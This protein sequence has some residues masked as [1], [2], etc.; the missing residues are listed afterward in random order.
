MRAPAR[1][2]LRS[3]TFAPAVTLILSTPSW[4]AHAQGAAEPK[5]PAQLG[6]ITVQT[7]ESEPSYTAETI[8]LGKT[9]QTLR[10]T[11]QSVSVITRQ[12]IEDQN[13]T[14]LDD[15]LAQSTGITVRGNP[16]NAGFYSRGFVIQQAQRDGVPVE[17]GTNT[18]L[19]SPDLAIYERVEILRGAAGL[20]NGA[21]QPGGTLNL[22]RKRALAETRFQTTATA[23]SWNNYR[24][25]ADATGELNGSGTLRGRLV[26]VYHSQESFRD[27]MKSDRSLYYGRIEYDLADSTT[28]SAGGTYE[29]RH[30]V[31]DYFGL[32]RYTTGEDLHLNRDTYLGVAW[33]RWDFK[34]PELFAELDH[35]WSDRWS[36]RLAATR[37]KEDSVELRKSVDGAI[38]PATLTGAVIGRTG[39]VDRDGTQDAVDLSLSGSFEG[40][41]RRHDVILGT[42][43]LDTAADVLQ[44]SYRLP[45]PQPIDVFNFDPNAYV[46]PDTPLTWPAQTRLLATQSGVYGL[47]RLRPAERLTLSAGG[48]WSNYRSKTVNLLTGAKTADN[49]LDGEFTPYGGVVYDLATNWSLYASYTDIFQVQNSYTFEGELLPPLVGKNYETGI[50]GEWLE[51]T[52]NGSLAL[53]RIDQSNRAQPDPLHR[54][55][56]PT[57]P[58]ASCS[59]AEGEVR[60]EGVELELAGRP[61][62]GLDLTAGYTYNTTEVIRDRTATGSPSAK[63]GGGFD[64]FTPKNILRAWASYRLPGRLQAFRVGAGVTAQSEYNALSS[65][66]TV[67][68]EPF[69]RQGGYTLW[70]AQ[71]SYAVSERITVS[72]NGNNLTDKVYYRSIDNYLGGFNFYGD[73]RNVAL[74]LRA[75]F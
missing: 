2:C 70:N 64:T 19:A 66:Y 31:P 69:A 53:F 63:E 11:P 60:S 38:D 41:G 34:K 54:G 15:A 47:L 27:V 56:C 23:A 73:P 30:M 74:S 8:T 4:V 24:L 49:K 45:G 72:L 13:L 39:I 21:G 10:E 12:R 40:F 33:T 22:V 58:T 62:T 36:S 68:G 75:T 48:R 14:R 5:D 71:A 52:L 46:M 35:R 55:L 51:G 26:G 61:F 7:T 9:A 29:K 50:K 67:A 17:I 3:L 43:Y 6:K 32:P 57:S 16:Q 44:G 1:G 25:E 65:G 37:V 18:S 28:F 59:I 20:L 42:N